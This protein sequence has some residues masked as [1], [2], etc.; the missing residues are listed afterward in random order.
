MTCPRWILP[1]WNMR[2]DLTLALKE[3]HARA[4]LQNGVVDGPTRGIGFNAEAF[5]DLLLVG[6]VRSSVHYHAAL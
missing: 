1:L 6:N 3:S 2:S 5:S 4:R